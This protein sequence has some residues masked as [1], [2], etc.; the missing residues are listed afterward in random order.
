MTIDSDM[1]SHV[2]RSSALQMVQSAQQKG[3]RILGLSE[4][5]FQMQETRLA[6]QHL[7]LEGPLL[8]FND[9]IDGVR[10]ASSQ[11]NIDVRLGLEVDFIP[12]KNEQIQAFLQ[13]YSWDFLIGSVH[14]VNEIQF[15]ANYKWN[16]E[17]GEALWLHYF[18][19]IRNAVTSGYFSVISHPV[20]MRAKNPYLPSTFDE[21]L[22]HLASDATYHDV[23]LEMNGYD[24]LHYFSLVRRLAKACLLQHTPISVGSD[25]HSPVEIMQAHQQTEH[26]LHETGITKIRLWKQMQIEEYHF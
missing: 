11:S 10:R 8:S 18:E 5:V 12:E 26:M 20:R 7:N 6:L 3:V 13:G 2:S 16:R 23:A 9:Y 21:E 19:L 14:Q 15:E 24:I 1:H 4:H 22:E 17:E 25:A